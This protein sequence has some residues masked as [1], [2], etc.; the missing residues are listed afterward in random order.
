ML[1]PL[2]AVLLFLNVT[3]GSRSSRRCL[4]ACCCVGPFVN[5][6]DLGLERLPR[7]IPLNTTVLSLARNKLCNIDHQLFTYLWLQELSL[8]NNDLSRIPKG[9]PSSLA[10]L[11]LQ[12]NRITYLTANEMRRLENLT[13]LDLGANRISVI[14]GA[15]F[16][17]LKKLQVLNLKDNR[18]SSIP[19]SL[20][21]ALF[22]LDVSFNCISNIHQTSL[23][24]LMNL[25]I[26]KINNNCLKYVPDR[27]FDSLPRLTAVELNNNSWVCECEIMYLYRWLLNGRLEAATELV[28]AAPLHL[29]RRLLLTLSVVAICP[30]ILKPN[31]TMQQNITVS[32]K[33]SNIVKKLDK[34]LTACPLTSSHSSEG[35][36]QAHTS[37]ANEQ[38]NTA[39][40]NFKLNAANHQ[41]ILDQM[42][43]DDCQ[44]VDG[45]TTPATEPP[46][47]EKYTPEDVPNHPENPTSPRNVTSIEPTAPFQLANKSSFQPATHLHPTSKQGASMLTAVLAALCVLVFLV[48]LAVLLILKK[49][50]ERDQRVAPA[51]RIP[52]PS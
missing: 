23:A 36:F 32:T 49:I 9:L 39:R 7:T 33:K 51:E 28:C 31:D 5:C 27:T 35:L 16:K 45:S 37:L 2:C 26:L 30:H 18:L 13:R 46:M 12:A 19:D 38:E 24:N 34:V 29:A 8:S 20:P 14:Q 1:G 40:K 43:L 3:Q 41:Y 50:L 10:V 42:N 4:Q 6:N 48:L 11:I 15:T 25:Q 52:E 44:K 47:P 21:T 22:Q 17:A